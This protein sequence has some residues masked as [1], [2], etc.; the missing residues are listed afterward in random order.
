MMMTQYLYFTFLFSFWGSILQVGRCSTCHL[1]ESSR[2]LYNVQCVYV[3]LLDST[4]WSFNAQINTTYVYLVGWSAVET[5]LTCA[6][7]VINPTNSKELVRQNHWRIFVA[8]SQEQQSVAKRWTKIVGCITTCIV[9]FA[10]NITKKCSVHIIG[11]SCCVNQIHLLLVLLGKQQ[12]EN[13]LL[14]DCVH[15]IFFWLFCFF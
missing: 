4:W 5:T 3:Y 11:F 15:F 1:N 13:G 10:T 8:L 14:S 12:K 2:L 9:Q 7:V 6:Q